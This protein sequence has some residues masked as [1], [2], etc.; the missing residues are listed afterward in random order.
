MPTLSE[1]NTSLNEANKLD[2][3]FKKNF[4]KTATVSNVG[5]S[6]EI[7]STSN[8]NYAK[9]TWLDNIKDVTDYETER[10]GSGNGW[11]SS[12]GVVQWYDGLVLSV[13]TG[14]SSRV[15]KHDDLKDSIVFF[16]TYLNVVTVK[17][18][19][20]S[21]LNEELTKGADS[22]GGWLI[23]SS[24]GALVFYAYGNVT[25]KVDSSNPPK[26][27]F[28]R[29]IG[30]KLDSVDHEDDRRRINTLEGLV[31]MMEVTASS[32]NGGGGGGSG[33]GLSLNGGTMYS[34]NNGIDMSSGNITNAGT[35]SANILTGTLSA[36]SSVQPNITTLSALQSVGAS[37]V[38]TTFSGNIIVNG[39]LKV[40]GHSDLSDGTTGGVGGGGGG[41]TNGEFTSL[42]VASNYITLGNVPSPGVNSDVNASGGG[43]KLKGDTDKTLLWTNGAGWTLSGGNLNM[44]GQLIKDVG[45]P[46]DDTDLATKGYVD[47]AGGL[48]QRVHT[49]EGAV[50]SQRIA[51]G[52]LD[53]STSASISSVNSNM[54]KV[55]MEVS[56]LLNNLFHYSWNVK[57][58]VSGAISQTNK[59]SKT[60][61]LSSINTLLELDRVSQTVKYYNSSRTLVRTKN[62]TYTSAYI[63]DKSMVGVISTSGSTHNVQFYNTDGNELGSIITITSDASVAGARLNHLGTAFVVHL[64]NGALQ[65]FVVY[66]RSGNNWSNLDSSL[67]VS[68]PV[69]W[70]IRGLVVA[71][72]SSAQNL[73]IYEWRNQSWQQKGQTLSE[74]NALTVNF[75]PLKKIFVTEQSKV[76]VYQ[77]SD[78]TSQW[79]LLHLITHTG[80]FVDFTLTTDYYAVRIVSNNGIIAMRLNLNGEW[81]SFGTDNIN[82][83]D[84]T[85]F[86]VA[87]SSNNMSLLFYDKIYNVIS[88]AMSSGINTS[89]GITTID[90]KLVCDNNIVFGKK[91]DFSITV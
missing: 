62:Y 86:N 45:E 81:E 31:H 10:A 21:N 82:N 85:Y 6:S 22:G 57:E 90:G 51:V 80:P 28:Y 54:Q 29:Y 60:V 63:I 78:E 70:D 87:T 19:K 64:T 79:V 34:G 91:S 67:V 40:L 17:V 37:S 89:N 41:S 88:S 2:I 1:S 25:S 76:A 77:L 50:Q 8:I 42:T 55:N 74:P 68:N 7:L 53:T 59:A 66:T 56:S 23:D 16:G 3:L 4:G 47:N 75:D 44:G 13:V 36:L 48:Q 35:V 32:G 52:E 73:E 84:G 33:G 38:N 14:T 43:I 58:D 39:N 20:T 15:Y 61:Q 26:V 46:I 69:S 12:D 18:T 71:Y 49:L 30:R 5:W 24:S 9:D 11:K 83:S 27:S 72:I 65:T